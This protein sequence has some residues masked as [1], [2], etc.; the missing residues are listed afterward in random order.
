MKFW[1]DSKNDSAKTSTG[2]A[3]SH[4]EWQLLFAKTFA[5]DLSD[6]YR[7]LL[8]HNRHQAKLAFPIARALPDFLDSYQ[9][10]F[11]KKAPRLPLPQLINE[12]SLRSE[13][14]SEL[15]SMYSDSWVKPE[16]QRNIDLLAERLVRTDQVLNTYFWTSIMNIH[17]VTPFSKPQ[18]DQIIK[19]F[20]R[21][22]PKLLNKSAVEVQNEG[23]PISLGIL[24]FLSA[25]TSINAV[26]LIRFLD[27]SS[28]DRGL[29]HQVLAELKPL[30]LRASARA[31]WDEV[32]RL[33]HKDQK[34]M[35]AIM[36]SKS[37]G[38]DWEEMRFLRAASLRILSRLTFL[39]ARSIQ[40]PK[41][42]QEFSYK[43]IESL[44]S[45]LR[46]NKKASEMN[47]FTSLELPAEAGH[48]TLQ[49]ILNTHDQ[50]S[51]K[52][53]WLDD[54]IEISSA[55]KDIEDWSK[56]PAETREAFSHS[57]QK[58][59]ASLDAESLKKFLHS[60]N[61]PHLLGDHELAGEISRYVNLA[62]ASAPNRHEKAKRILNDLDNVSKLSQTRRRAWMKAQDQAA[63]LNQAQPG[64]VG[65]YTVSNQVGLLR[66]DDVLVRLAGDLSSQ[67]RALSQ[68]NIL[69]ALNYLMGHTDQPPTVNETLQRSM[70]EVRSGLLN[71]EIGIR[72]LAA[73]IL[74]TGPDGIVFKKEGLS[75]LTEQLL[76]PLPIGHR[77]ELGRAILEALVEME[78]LNRSLAFALVKGQPSSIMRGKSPEIAFLKAFVEATGV[79]GG[80]LAQYLAFTN[81]FS[82]FGEA[83]SE[84]QDQ[85][86]PMSYIQMLNEVRSSVGYKWSEQNQILGVAGYGTVNVAV[87]YVKKDRPNDVR[88][89]KFLRK[90]IENKT[91][92]D[93]SRM[94][95]LL[96]ILRA[97][98][99]KNREYH[100]ISGLLPMIRRS[101]QKEFSQAHVLEINPLASEIYNT[102]RRGIQIKAIP[103]D[104]AVS[105]SAVE[106]AKAN[107][108]TAK[109]LRERDF[110][111]YS[112][113]MAA[114]LE[115]ERDVLLGSIKSSDGRSLVN[116]DIHNG[117]LIIDSK[118]NR[119][120]LIDMSQSSVINESER[121]Q[122]IAVLRVISKLHSVDKSQ[123][124]LKRHFSVEISKEELKE[125]LNSSSRMD[126]FVHLI[127]AIELKGVIVPTATADWI[128][129]F[130]RWITLG[131]GIG[132]NEAE[133]VKP[134]FDAQGGSILLD[135][136]QGISRIFSLFSR[137]HKTEECARLLESKP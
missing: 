5:R 90:S 79:P 117:Q 69:E 103:V 56:I 122:A 87:F 77:R 26:D 104:S 24:R 109:S 126:S 39:G 93:F 17:Q 27:V 95:R 121:S 68:Q 76:S 40:D 1:L 21:D 14:V 115:L 47:G 125:I 81:G 43:D 70:K 91:N 59:L 65:Q 101:L 128:M 136:N 60:K 19:K 34:S 44:L 25:A 32:G 53:Q 80:K 46:I 74:L 63:E 3:Q 55:L 2:L 16:P 67:I 66:G 48:F 111:S 123:E 30:L 23:Q 12:V 58:G 72:V 11:F 83:F 73:N 131:K 10:L 86:F 71:A 42:S 102:S 137:S 110:A 13:I 45:E 105:T 112:R 85:P 20:E 41:T 54:L 127:A 107:G 99:P 82:E 88:V 36:T 130:D 62:A 96:D 33:T 51:S 114:F 106:M 38:Q 8:E 4:P 84:F 61:A 29:N 18:L 52:N 49:L 64:D 94:S 116:P 100:S 6:L 134:F 28:G 92:F 78:D 113:Y 50:Y 31:I 133:L 132:W 129:A 22:L 97:R 135:I 15:K 108:V 57:L 120:A 37:K 119:M 9:N 89:L 124:I 7:I 75:A 98:F 35:W 118:E